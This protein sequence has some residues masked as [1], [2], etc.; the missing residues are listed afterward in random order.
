[1]AATNDRDWRESGMIANLNSGAH[2]SNK[3][4]DRKALLSTG[5]ENKQWTAKINCSNGQLYCMWPKYSVCR[6]DN[7]PRRR[8]FYATKSGMLFTSQKRLFLTNLNEYIVFAVDFVV[9]IMGKDFGLVVPKGRST[10]AKLQRNKS[11]D[12]LRISTICI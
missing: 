8:A 2:D 3:F 12:P 11:L 9:R 6:G 7:T 5:Q 1:L 4:R 10:E